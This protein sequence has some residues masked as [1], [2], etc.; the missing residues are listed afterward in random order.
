MSTHSP[1]FLMYWDWY[2]NKNFGFLIREKQ[3]TC[4]WFLSL[5]RFLWLLFRHFLVLWDTHQHVHPKDWNFI[6]FSIPALINSWSTCLCSP[7][8]C[9]FILCFLKIRVHLATYTCV[10]ERLI[11]HFCLFKLFSRSYLCFREIVTSFNVSLNFISRDLPVFQTNWYLISYL[12]KLYFQGLTWVSDRLRLC[13]SCFLSWPT[14]YWFFSKACSSFSSCDG[15]NA[16]RIRFGFRNG[17]RN[18]GKS[19]PGIERMLM[20]LVN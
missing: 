19:G 17:S 3:Y 6:H 11:L 5:F 9:Y 12:F 4:I 13:A 2:K 7:K 18:A 16:V 1:L 8:D 14:T 20:W 10:S 15:L